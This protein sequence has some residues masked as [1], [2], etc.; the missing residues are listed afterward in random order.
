M[1]FFNDDRY[2]K[3]IWI[4]LIG[5]DNTKSDFGIADY[6][7]RAGFMPDGFSLLLYWADFV[8]CH[9]GS[10]GDSPLSPAECSYG[11]HEYN[12][13]RRRQE[14]TK[15]QLRA[16]VSAVHTRG[17]KVYLSFFNLDW[18]V[19]D[20]GRAVKSAYFKTDALRET[21]R[22]GRPAG[23]INVLKK[24][25]DGNYFE[26]VL[27][28]KTIETMK[29]YNFDGLQIADGIS[30][31]RVTLQ[32]GDYSDDMVRQFTDGGVRLPD[33]HRC[34]LDRQP[35][36]LAP[37]ADYIWKN[38]RKEWIY[39]NVNRWNVFYKK[40]AG[41]I[42]GAGFECIF[43]SAWTRDPFEAMYRYGVDYRQVVKSG[44]IG[45]M[46]EDVGAGLSIL[47]ESDNLYL[48]NDDERKKIHY[49]FI[50]ALMLNRA[51]MPGVRI[52]PLA[53]IH[54]T[55]EQWGVLEHMPTLMARNVMTNLNTYAVTPNGLKSVT[56]GPFYCLGDNLK[57]H[58]W[59]FIRRL[60]DTGATESPVS[61]EGVTLVWSDE[62]LDAEL[63]AFITSRRTPTQKIVSELLYAGA[64]VSTVVRI[65]D[66]P[67]A[68]GALL[69]TNP[70]LLPGYQ[71]ESIL[72]YDNGP[73]FFIGATDKKFPG[74]FILLAEE[75]NT[76]GGF[77]LYVKNSPEPAAPVIINNDENYLFDP[78][79]SLEA[80][81][82][83]WTHSLDFAPVSK[84]FYAA[85]REFIIDI[86]KAPKVEPST[87][88]KNGGPYEPCKTICVNTAPDTCRLFVSNDDYF[89]NIPSIDLKRTIKTA[90]CLTKYD[91]Y[92]VNFNGSVITSRIP[93]RGM[94]CFEI[95]FE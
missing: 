68:R 66:L 3:W 63:D 94:E 75:Q 60:W 92:K 45:C 86:T 72:K 13:E 9:D 56:D 73:V 26:D 47:S 15:N 11:G 44:V 76:F 83:I 32:N 51:A 39:F 33:I 90:R 42:S 50:T 14:W 29:Y 23:G 77:R 17:I 21:D 19:T 10:S 18:Y 24:T 57:T 88:V 25:P 12:P 93:C 5:F 61:V 84:N 80:C 48:M 67:H 87:I 43:N 8:L 16:F 89:Y 40:F 65:E 55:T 22:S 91:G 49:E 59:D 70:D 79:N 52:T 27:T 6:L 95:T 69:I 38:L 4:E 53:G 34:D 1:S 58:D 20:D 81:G 71:M 28:D 7:N 62:R 37:R 74:D 2:Q 64:P 35:E 41:S 82:M 36:K 31:P 54:D 46:V 85:C 78:I 30:S